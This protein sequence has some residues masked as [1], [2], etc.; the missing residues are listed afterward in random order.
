MSER[1]ESAGAAG[2]AEA[3]PDAALSGGAGAAAASASQCTLAFQHRNPGRG[4]APGAAAAAPAP[5]GG[6][7]ASTAG[8]ADA[9]WLAPPGSLIGRRVLREFEA[10]SFV[11]VILSTRFT[12]AYG[13]L[14]HVRYDDGD[15]E[16]LA[17]TELQD[18]L[19]PADARELRESAGA[20]RSAAVVASA[21]HAAAVPTGSGAAAD[22]QLPAAERCYKGVS[23]WVSRIY[24]FERHYRAALWVDGVNTL[25]GNFC[26][27][28]EAARAYDDAARVHGRLVVNFP[29]AGTEEVQAVPG[30][31]AGQR[32][33]MTAAAVS[34]GHAMAQQYKGVGFGAHST[35]GKQYYAQFCFKGVPRRLGGFATALKA[36]RAF[37][38][39]AR[40]L[41][42]VQ[43][44]FPRPG[45]AETQ[46]VRHGRGA[47]CCQSF[48][49]PRTCGTRAGKLGCAC[50]HAR[51]LTAT[52]DALNAHCRRG[53]AP[54][55]PAGF[56]ACSCD[57]CA[58]PSAGAA[59]KA[60]PHAC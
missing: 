41:G 13:Q 21:A 6:A 10:G 4:A 28:V 46:A 40:T 14:W 30:Q 44:N 3:A 9:A 42:K 34:R 58:S 18:A 48:A 43:L 27:A 2:G 36:A 57:W 11:G 52:C 22:G 12:R 45:T 16:D 38:E 29:R 59:Q 15:V 17:W 7:G 24:P 50:W 39:H 35:V 37:D 54:F 60:R 51:A 26:T 31:L 49:C 23:S 33:V 1:D 56:A 5:G 20:G 47:S 53:R 55:E 19:R 25:P 8:H 32:A